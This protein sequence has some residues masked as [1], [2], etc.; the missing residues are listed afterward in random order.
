M[1]LPPLPENSI[2]FIGDMDIVWGFTAVQMRAYATA[3]IMQADTDAQDAARYQWLRHGDNDETV[4][5][6]Y[7]ESV[8]DAPTMYLPRLSQLDKAIDAAMEQLK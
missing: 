3:A 5:Q 1:N 8:F 4:L 2:L 6:K 7:K